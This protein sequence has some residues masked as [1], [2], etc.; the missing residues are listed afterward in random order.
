MMNRRTSTE[1]V[2][3]A[4]RITL[5]TVTVKATNSLK[6]TVKEV[7]YSAVK[8][9]SKFETQRKRLRDGSDGVSL[10]RARA[11]ILHPRLPT[12]T[13]PVRGHKAN[14]KL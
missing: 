6:L 3:V 12:Y 14:D 13:E 4:E 9:V 5:L 8:P 10:A 2:R 7:R 11:H 1:P